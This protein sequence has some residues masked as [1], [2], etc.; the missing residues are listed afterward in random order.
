MFQTARKS[1]IKIVWLLIVMQLYLLVCLIPILLMHFNYKKFFKL[2]K[3]K[4][5]RNKINTLQKH[6]HLLSSKVRQINL[7]LQFP[8]IF[9]TLRKVSI[10]KILMKLLLHSTA[11]ISLQKPYKKFR[12]L[13]IL[14]ISNSPK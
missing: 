7:N 8:T 10:M 12:L 11:A 3:S 6:H 14:R 5:K 9:S 4:T 2:V 13:R 1:S